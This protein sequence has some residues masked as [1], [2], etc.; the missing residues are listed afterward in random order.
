ME[1]E[2]GNF[3]TYNIYDECGKDQ[4]RRKLSDRKITTNHS[5]PP[6]DGGDGDGNDLDQYEGVVAKWRQILSQKTV[7]VSTSESM[8]LNAGLPY[9]IAYNYEYTHTYTHAYS[10]IYAPTYANTCSHICI[11]YSQALN[12]YA[13]GGETAMSVWLDEPSVIEALHVKAGTVGTSSV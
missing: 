11:G 3:N 12:D 10:H 2:M 6:T 8:T 1:D 5:A 9:I 7:S 4:R 13:C